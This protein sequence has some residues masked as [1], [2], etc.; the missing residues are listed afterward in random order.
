MDKINRERV[1]NIMSD[2]KF[3]IDDLFNEDNDDISNN[4]EKKHQKISSD[5]IDE[6]LASVKKKNRPSEIK[7]DEVVENVI[8]ETVPDV[9]DSESD[10]VAAVPV[11]GDEKI[12]PDEAKKDSELKKHFGKNSD[13]EE[14]EEEDE[15]EEE[16]NNT[17]VKK[18]NEKHT[19]TPKKRK[20]RSK[21]GRKKKKKGGIGFNG[22][23]FGGIILVTI[24]L[25]VSMLL[26]VGGLTVGMEFYGIGKDENDISFNIPEGSTNEEIADLLFENGIIKNKDLFLMAVK[27][28]KPKK[29]YPGDIT[30]KPSMSYS[31]IIEE[32]EVQRERYETVTLTF[33]EGSY[34]VDIADQ[35][36][37]ANVCSADDFLFEFKKDLGYK[38]ES[39]IT[40]NEN[41]FYSREGYC[42]PD[43]Y[44]F[45]VGDTAY[46]I[47]KI[48]REHFD[49]KITDSMYTKMNSMG[50]TLNDTMTLASIVQL[51]AANVDEMPRIASVFLNRLNDPDTFP[52]L[53]TDTTYKYI[54]QVIKK[55]A[56]N[57][58]MVAHFTEYYDTYAIDG[59][60][61]GPICNPGIE[62]INAVLNP[63]KTN[64]YYFC[65]N[66]E[67]GETF[68]AETLEEHEA[69]QIK[70]GL[71]EAVE[72]DEDTEEDNGEEYN[73]YY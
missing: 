10:V 66:L 24:I 62:A 73:E 25:T 61:A 23:I 36:E 52:M 72:N 39:Y 71:I 26:A 64:Y 69:N 6:L 22:S 31:D 51:E 65:N 55:K 14:A 60:P 38:F 17:P 5:E 29:I 12:L 54:D 30:L 11:I 47:T 49:S 9:A 37:Q 43:T 32:M 27:L 33:I 68:Y 42:F 34:L 44:E 50:L 19:D 58:D 20:K 8:E 63:E 56:G 70:A 53:Q 41:A 21:K 45:Y 15:D 35:L 48:L 46:N 16:T 28:M 13:D 1:N 2:K 40:D 59:L 4:G 57:D 67:T 18:E 7:T 3:D